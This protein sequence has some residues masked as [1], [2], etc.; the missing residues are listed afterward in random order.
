MTSGREI[1]KQFSRK[2]WAGIGSFILWNLY[3]VK[4]KDYIINL[5]ATE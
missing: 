1:G 4:N 2:T 3:V 5:W